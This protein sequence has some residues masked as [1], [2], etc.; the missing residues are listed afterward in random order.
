[1]REELCAPTSSLILIIYHKPTTC[2]RADKKNDGAV[3]RPVFSEI[4]RVLY[5]YFVAIFRTDARIAAEDVIFRLH[6]RA[7][8]QGTF[9]GR[10]SAFHCCRCSSR[11]A[12]SLR[13]SH[14]AHSARRSKSCCLSSSSFFLL[15]HPESKFL[16]K[17]IL[18]IGEV[19][20]DF[21]LRRAAQR[22]DIPCVL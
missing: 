3:I 16:S 22:T 9:I 14:S 17:V 1:M 5:G 18:C 12:N 6:V 4:V 8:L 2:N 13:S 10:S 11:S 20:F 19:D 21:P 15:A 7:L